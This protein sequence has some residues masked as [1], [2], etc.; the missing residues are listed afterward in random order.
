MPLEVKFAVS[1]DNKSFTELPSVKNTVGERTNGP[2][3]KDFTVKLNG[4]SAR[5]IRVQAVNRVNCPAWHPGAGKKAWV[6]VDEI[7]IK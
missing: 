3:V 4:K 5:Y 6:F 2:V 1:A 7:V